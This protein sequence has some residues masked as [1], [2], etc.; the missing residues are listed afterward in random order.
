MDT[1]STIRTSN[2]D[3]RNLIELSGNS[4]TP[5]P[6]IVFFKC[7]EGTEMTR[8]TATLTDLFGVTDDR[9]R[10]FLLVAMTFAILC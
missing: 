5:V 3:L 6:D 9:F 1:W 10:T 8:I 2:N 7:K 4:L